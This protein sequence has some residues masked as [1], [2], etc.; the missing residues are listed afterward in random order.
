MIRECIEAEV[1]I[2]FRP[3]M[4]EDIGMDY[5]RLYPVLKDRPE[6]IY[7]STQLPS[8]DSELRVKD[9]TKKA[10]PIDFEELEDVADAIT[11]VHDEINNGTLWWWWRILEHVPRPVFYQDDNGD[12][13]DV[14][15]WK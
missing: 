4:F 11:K 3:E 6:I 9:L 15:T 12:D 13:R 10:I 14:A 5:T 7:H 2:R 8:P 1:G